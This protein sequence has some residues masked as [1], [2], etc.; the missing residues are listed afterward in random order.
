MMADVDETM[1]QPQAAAAD[2]RN[3]LNTMV[4]GVN[5]PTIDPTAEIE[6]DDDYRR[7]VSR[8]NDVPD[9]EG[10][11]E[12]KAD[13]GFIKT[14]AKRYFRL[15]KKEAVMAYFKD[16]KDTKQL[17][18]ISLR[19]M[20]MVEFSKEKKFAF[21]LTMKTIARVFFLAAKD[22]ESRDAWIAHIKPFLTGGPGLITPDE[23]QEM[24]EAGSGKKKKPTGLPLTY[25]PQI[26]QGFADIEMSVSS[27]QDADDSFKA[28]PV[29]PAVG[30]VHLSLHGDSNSVI[31]EYRSVDVAEGSA[32]LDDLPR[33]LR[34]T[35][36]T[37]TFQA[38]DAAWKVS[39][40]KL[41]VEDPT[42][43]NL[44]K[45]LIGQEIEVSLPRDRHFGH[46]AKFKGT[47]IYHHDDDSY[48]LHDQG[49]NHV[50][51]LK[52]SDP[53]TYNLLLAKPTLPEP[54]PPN[55]PAIFQ[56]PHI[57][58]QLRNDAGASGTVEG[59]LS[60]RLASAFEWKIHYNLVLNPRERSVDVLGWASVL[61]KSGKTYSNASVTLITPIGSGDAPKEEKKEGNAVAEVVEEK[62]EEKKGGLFGKMKLPSLPI[63][64]LS[65]APKPKPAPLFYR[66]PLAG[67][68]TLPAS[69]WSQ[70]ALF[71]EQFPCKTVFFVRFDTP[72]YSY[73]ASVGE[74]HGTDAP[75]Q[76]TTALK[77]RNNTEHD[78][79]AGSV[80]VTRHEKTGW[81]L[82]QVHEGKMAN[83][84]QKDVITVD[85]EDASNITATRKQTGFTFNTENNFLVESFEITVTNARME[86]VVVELEENLYRWQTFEVTSS[87]PQHGQGTH[88]RK[89]MWKL[90]LNHG[91]YQTIRYT[92]FYSKFELD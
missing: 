85:L 82:V 62:V 24:P 90:K 57:W 6:D 37:I 55:T 66:F 63:P 91:E 80:N 33:K 41:Y 30:D 49:A 20:Y 78:L 17:G 26:V 7:G 51:F 67:P 54:A 40:L 83:Y 19:G 14:W 72:K 21:T 68:V 46:D 32:Y 81:G 56:P 8:E 87:S 35:K 43:E 13:K 3:R 89:I 22:E 73:K 10:F 84:H 42:P 29:T 44:L 1:D 47:V 48:V 34:D 52:T 45:K 76:I 27:L 9:Y 71:Q 61:N 86:T 70:V 64:G 75:A 23:D 12:K 60:Y 65:D 5:H 59:S 77:F 38:T 31:E 4:D 18:Q 15:Y 28:N 36:H 58:L 11:L 88:P 2:G 50:H 53:H 39:Q 16:Q 25:P 74:K 69:Q 92:V 79:L